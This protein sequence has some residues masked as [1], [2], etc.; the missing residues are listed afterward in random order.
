MIQRRSNILCLF[1]FGVA[2]GFAPP[3][4]AQGL[5]GYGATS[6][7]AP[8][9][10]GG[11]GQIIPYGGSLRGF[12]PSRMSGGGT[13]LSF[14]SRNSSMIGTARSSFR[15]SSMSGEMSSSFGAMGRNFGSRALMSASPSSSGLGGGMNRAM[16]SVRESVTPPNFG[17][18]FYQPPYLL[19]T[20]P[21]FAGMPSM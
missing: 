12:M 19:G 21:V 10:M 9:G 11:S 8:Y 6:S 2:F 20:S 15:L 5:G 1:V 18:P 13:G 16:D 7:M 14:S 3:A 4:H 17:Y